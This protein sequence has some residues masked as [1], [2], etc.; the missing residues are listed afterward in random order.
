MKL[1]FKSQQSCKRS[2]R[3]YKRAGGSRKN[4]KK[5]AGA[6]KG[7]YDSKGNLNHFWVK[8]NG[9]SHA[10]FVIDPKGT[11]TYCHVTLKYK[12]NPTL[13]HYGFEL[14]N[15]KHRAMGK[16]FWT[17]PYKDDYKLDN[18]MKD[19][20]KEL[21][22]KLCDDDKENTQ[23]RHTLMSSNTS[24]RRTQKSR[25]TRY[26]RDVPSTSNRSRSNSPKR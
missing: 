12:G 15:P 24:R 17:T 16:H 10:S 25:N 11:G 14:N 9:N 2:N 21:F 3:K 26:D 23:S 1:N 22:D 4:S 6:P 5:K 7:P 20:L 13:Y 18:S 19:Y 8:E